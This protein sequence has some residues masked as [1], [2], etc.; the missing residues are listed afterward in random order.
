M[1]DIDCRLDL[2]ELSAALPQEALQSIATAAQSEIEAQAQANGMSLIAVSPAEQLP[3]VTVPDNS[4]PSW[5]YATGAV[6]LLLLV[7]IPLA[8]YVVYI[9]TR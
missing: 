1:I 5:A 8:M 3:T 9:N 4:P 6:V 2:S 7:T